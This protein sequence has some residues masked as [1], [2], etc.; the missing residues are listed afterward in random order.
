MSDLAVADPSLA[1]RAI[2]GARHAMEGVLLPI[3][4]GAVKRYFGTAAA[5][6]FFSLVLAA[7]G[8]AIAAPAPWWAIS[9]VMAVAVAA[10]TVGGI[11]LAPKRAISGAIADGLRRLGLGRVVCNLVFDRLLGVK[12]EEQHGERGAAVAQRAERVPL[13]T[14]EERLRAIVDRIASD[15]S[16]GK[17]LRA[18]FRRKIR[19]ALLEQIERVTLARFRDEAQVHGGVDLVKVKEELSVAIDERLVE[20]FEG[21]AGATTYMV[22]GAVVTVSM[23]VAV[24]VRVLLG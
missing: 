4:G 7:L 24:T 2:A 8:A 3:A 11:V 6:G 12:E 14:A 20:R 19:N 9:L 5:M 18:W 21:A 1:Q 15:P 13:A 22:L 17:G 10:S 16:E 23:V